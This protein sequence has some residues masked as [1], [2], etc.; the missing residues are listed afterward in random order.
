MAYLLDNKY[1]SVLMAIT[2]KAGKLR[3]K[4]SK[5]INWGAACTTIEVPE[6][7]P[8]CLTIATKLK[9]ENSI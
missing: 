6:I 7:S 1:I 9:L 5:K 2:G 8:Y 3:E 4:E